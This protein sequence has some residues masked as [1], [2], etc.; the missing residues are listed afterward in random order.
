M[1][2]SVSKPVDAY[3]YIRDEIIAGRLKAG[4]AL[5]ERGIADTLDIGRTPVRE[6][7]KKLALEGLLDIA[8]MQGTFVRQLSVNDLREIHEI[9]LM[10]E[11]QAVQLACA[12]GGDTRLADIMQRLQRVLER[13]Q[14][15]VSEAQQ[16]GW[17]FHDVLFEATQNSRL[18]KMY[19]DLRAQNGLALQALPFY[20][21]DRTR[22]AV[23]EH[24]QIIQAVISGDV[25]TARHLMRA[26]INDAMKARLVTLI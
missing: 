5:S 23:Q 26:H 17:L 8:P 16:L 19:N 9:R 4:T 12:Q 10:L 7:I 15:H 11:D 25:P 21:A 1:N 13:D 14:L 2:Q 24:I 3:S 20:D 22:I 6:A 18:C